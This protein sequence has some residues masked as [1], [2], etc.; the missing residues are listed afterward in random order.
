M[1]QKR[2]LGKL[3]ELETFVGSKKQ[4]LALDGR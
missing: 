3:E 2:H 4:D 1:P